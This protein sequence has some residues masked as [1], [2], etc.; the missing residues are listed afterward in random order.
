[1]NL[2]NEKDGVVFAILS[3]VMWGLTPIY[4]KLTQYISS[5]EILAQRVLWSFIS[6]LVLL[7]LLKKWN[8]YVEF[9]KEIIKKPKLFWSLFLASVLISSNWGIFMW[10]VIEGKIVEASLGQYINPLTSMLIGVIVL[11]E[12]ISGSQVLA[13]IL[14]GMGM[15]TLTLHYGV[16]PWISLSLALTF[17]FYGLAKKLIKADSTIGLALETMMITPIAIVFLTYLMFQS[18]IEFFNSVSTSLL[19]IGSGAVTVLP[20]LLFTMSAKKVTL[21]LLGILQYISPTIV[22]VSGVLLYNE[23]LS[24]AHLI[25][26]IFIWSALVIYIFS[27]ITKRGK[28]SK[29]HIKSKMEA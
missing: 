23:T 9:V 17:G 18:Q 1:M 21:S 27:S 20:L 7:I 15:L 5:G 22:L 14:A 11:K 8:I 29:V 2:N 12:K 28:K 6:M 16:I 13:F 10:A 25:A 4:W 26:F 19:L 3:Y 24:Q